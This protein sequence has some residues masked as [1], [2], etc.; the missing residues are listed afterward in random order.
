MIQ[1]REISLF[2]F[3]MPALSVPTFK[4]SWS[5]TIQKRDIALFSFSDAN[6]DDELKS[7]DTKTW[8]RQFVN[9]NFRMLQ[10]DDDDDKNG[11]YISSSFCFWAVFPR[12]VLFVPWKTKLLTTKGCPLLKGCKLPSGLYC[13]QFFWFSLRLF[14]LLSVFGFVAVWVFLNALLSGFSFPLVCCALWSL[15][16]FGLVLFFMWSYFQFL[17]WFPHFKDLESLWLE[18]M[19][20]ENKGQCVGRSYVVGIFRIHV[21]ALVSVAICQL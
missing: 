18:V 19:L 14:W 15:L 17:L 1:K 21:C 6:F 11:V 5:Q 9:A 12:A 4:M 7:D 2:H 8:A 13:S 3:L 16:S 20:L 10:D